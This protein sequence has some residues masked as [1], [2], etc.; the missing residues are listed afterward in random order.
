ML[1]FIR[2]FRV[3]GLVNVSHK[4]TP[5]GIVVDRHLLDVDPN[6]TFKFDAYLFD[7]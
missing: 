7:K 5:H 6:P 4:A 1:L 2:F 3:I